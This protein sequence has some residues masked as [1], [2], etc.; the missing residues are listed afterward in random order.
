MCLL[1]GSVV[2]RLSNDVTRVCGNQ[3]GVT[4]PIFPSH[5]LDVNSNSARLPGSATGYQEIRT[6]AST[7][8]LASLLEKQSRIKYK[9]TENN[10]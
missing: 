1:V 4:D 7:E 6:F 2:Y 8:Y 10:D 9:G 5:L 3:N